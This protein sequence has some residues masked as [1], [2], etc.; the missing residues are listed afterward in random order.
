MARI[1]VPDVD[2][3]VAAALEQL[4]R[5]RGTTPEQQVRELI[6]REVDLERRWAKFRRVSD[7]LLQRWRRDGLIRDARVPHTDR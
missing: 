5:D 3:R 4:A 6:E 7:D 2:D 1:I